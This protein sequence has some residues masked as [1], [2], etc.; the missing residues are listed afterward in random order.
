MIAS[1]PIDLESVVDVELPPL[2]GVALRVAALSHDLNSSNRQIA[3]AL[4]YDPI[5]AARILRAANS[6]IYYFQK[7]ITALPTAVTALGSE[8][9]Y[10]LV[11]MSATAD[12]FRKNRRSE[13]ETRLWEHSV[14]VAL[15][16]RELSAMLNFRAIEEAFLCGLLHDF[17]KLLM[18]RHNAA[19][20]T[21][22]LKNTGEGDLLAGEMETFGYT[23]AQVGALAAKRWNLPDEVSQAINFHHQPSQS[24]YPNLM[25]R[26]VDVADSLAYASGFG[27]QLTEQSLTESESVIALR[28]SE[29]QLAQVGTKIQSGSSD[30]FKMFS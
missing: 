20:Y 10:S 13:L 18:L 23:H 12:A 19:A 27:D 22:L 14:A 9:I 26:V 2:P 15:G 28:L 3:D 29:K 21:A 30:A 6:P 5:L 16:A 1:A 24:E 7:T 8:S 25:A 4:G 11:V 17:G